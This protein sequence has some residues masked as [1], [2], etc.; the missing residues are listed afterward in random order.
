MAV[1]AGIDCL[2]KL[3]RKTVDALYF[4]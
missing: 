4:A 2:G 1:A 3:D